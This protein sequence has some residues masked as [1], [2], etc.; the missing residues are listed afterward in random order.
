ML[1]K[2][3]MDKLLNKLMST[4]SAQIQMNGFAVTLNI[5]D[6]GPKIFLSTP[7]YFGG[8]Y[9]PKSV[10]GCVSQ[11]AP[12]DRLNIQTRLE[13]D[14]EGFQINLC[15]EGNMAL[16]GNNQL[17]TTLEDFSWLADKWRDYLDEH[18]KNDLV[19]IHIPVR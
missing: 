2:E 9:I 10:R 18:D 16:A 6:K 4:D 12:F 3:N 19:H 5:L 8:N 11:K 1:I 15:H 14:E 7:V 13:V 17:V